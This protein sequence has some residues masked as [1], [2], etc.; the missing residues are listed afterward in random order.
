MALATVISGS[1]FDN[2]RNVPICSRWSRPQTSLS[3]SVQWPASATQPEKSG[4]KR[5]TCKIL[6]NANV[7]SHKFP[8]D[9]SGRIGR[10]S[11]LV[12]SYGLFF[13]TVQG[14]QTRAIGLRS[15]DDYHNFAFRRMRL[16]VCMELGSRT[17]AEFLKFFCQL[18]C[19]TEL[20]IWHNAIASLKRF[21]KPVRRFKKKR[22]LLALS[23]YPQFA[24]ALAA[25]HRKESTK[26]ELVIGKSRTE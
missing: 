5:T 8:A 17:P 19:D 13:A 23:R 14:L 22:C 18:A 26:G 15:R 16:V 24:L 4:R 2:R 12:Y 6:E 10:R 20:P 25:F 11:R 9:F 21:K 3:E 7:R 1:S